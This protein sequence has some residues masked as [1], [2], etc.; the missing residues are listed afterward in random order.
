VSLGIRT[1]ATPAQTGVGVD[2]SIWK[3]LKARGM[4]DARGAASVGVGAETEW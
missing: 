2:I 3:Q 1:G 4:I